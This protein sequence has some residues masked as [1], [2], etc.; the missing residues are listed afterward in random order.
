MYCLGPY[1]IKA[2]HSRFRYFTC[3]S[4]HTM[5]LHFDSAN[6]IPYSSAFDIQQLGPVSPSTETN[7]ASTHLV[8]LSATLASHST[9]ALPNGSC[10]LLAT[11]RI[12]A[13]GLNGTRLSVRAL[14]DPGSQISLITK[15]LCNILSL[16]CTSTH[17]NIQGVGGN[18][19]CSF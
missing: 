1:H 18:S 11:D 17:V 3:E 7:H 16:K 12:N 2:S 6:E 5:L 13:I 14:I 10:I 9:K 19:C 15:S 8:D 4:K